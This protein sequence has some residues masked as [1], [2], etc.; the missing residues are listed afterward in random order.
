[1]LEPADFPSSQA[2]FASHSITADQAFTRPD[3][4]SLPTAYTLR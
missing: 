4:S 1:M 2:C 3:Q